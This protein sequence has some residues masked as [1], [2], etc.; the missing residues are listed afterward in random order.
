MG[1]STGV[2]GFGF[3]GVATATATTSGIFNTEQF[4]INDFGYNAGW[5]IEQHPRLTADITGDGRADIVG[6]GN[7]GIY[8]A[9]ARGDGTYQ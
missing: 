7:A 1:G 9:V 3:S 5:R 6:F 8:T 4:V 2:I